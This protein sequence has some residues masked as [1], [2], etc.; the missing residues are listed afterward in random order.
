MLLSL[1]AVKIVWQVVEMGDWER[2]FEVGG[3]SVDSI[4]MYGSKNIH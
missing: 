4:Y 1:L 3:R 2:N